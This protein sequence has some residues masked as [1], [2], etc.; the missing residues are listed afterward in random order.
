M[1][2]MNHAL[3]SCFISDN[4]VCLAVI[5]SVGDHAP[6]NVGGHGGRR[7]LGGVGGLGTAPSHQVCMSDSPIIP[8]LCPILSPHR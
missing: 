7:A 6:S 5:L 8:L 4:T 1:F 3:S 2:Q